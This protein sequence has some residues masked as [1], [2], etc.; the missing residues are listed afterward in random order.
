MAGLE[1][2]NSGNCEEAFICFE[3]AARYGYSK[4]HFNIGVCY[5]MGRGVHKDKEKVRIWKAQW[6]WSKLLLTLIRYQFWWFWCYSYQGS[7]SLLP[8]SSWRSQTG[9]VPLCKA[10]P[11]QQGSAEFR[12][13]EHSNRLTGTICCSWTHQGRNYFLIN[14]MPVV[15]MT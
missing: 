12:E 9:S 5:E 13:D 8:S 10:A 4:A 11:N 6:K 14:A 2:A 3:A 7:T 1:R 15:K